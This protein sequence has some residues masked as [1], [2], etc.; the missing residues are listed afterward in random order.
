MCQLKARGTGYVTG[1]SLPTV[2]ESGSRHFS[3][4]SYCGG[5]SRHLREPRSVVRHSRSG[6]R[7]GDE[8][9]GVRR[10]PPYRKFWTNFPLSL[11]VYSRKLRF[12][13]FRGLR[14]DMDHRST[15]GRMKCPA[16]MLPCGGLC[17]LGEL[18]VGY[19]GEPRDI[20]E[21][22]DGSTDPVLV[23]TSKLVDPQ[24][25]VK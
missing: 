18:G 10:K 3:S 20:H 24:L 22:M 16:G 14:H 5:G 17:V 13:A 19:R 9:F 8:W 11:F 12:P 2:C 7:L 1:C 15:S 23:D 21:R 6:C 25:C 4:E